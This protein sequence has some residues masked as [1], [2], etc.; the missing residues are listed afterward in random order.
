MKVTNLL[1]L[2]RKPPRGGLHVRAGG[3]ARPRSELYSLERLEEYARELAAEHSAATGP[4]AARPLLV[5]AE[6]SGQALEQ[7]YAQLSGA[8]HRQLALM[9]GDEWLLDNYHIVQ[10][11]VAEVTVDL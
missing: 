11:T 5:E 7:A 9:P 3:A 1:N 6:K 8:D 4:V 10:E 2:R